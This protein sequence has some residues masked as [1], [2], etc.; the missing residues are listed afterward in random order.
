MFITKAALHSKDNVKI[1]HY[2]NRKISKSSIVCHVHIGA[3][4]EYCT[5]RCMCRKCQHCFLFGYFLCVFHAV[6]FLLGFCLVDFLVLTSQ[7]QYQLLLAICCRVLIFVTCF[8]TA[9]YPQNKKVEYKF[10]FTL[11]YFLWPKAN[12]TLTWL[13]KSI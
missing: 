7:L 4:I 11:K 12:P 8:T 3:N 13:L 5:C 10:R 9:M 2:T 1:L 6:V